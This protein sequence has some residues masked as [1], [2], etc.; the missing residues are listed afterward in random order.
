MRAIIRFFLSL[1]TAVVFFAVF[2]AIA[3]AGS[4]SLVK[5][6]AFF[7][8]IDDTP[9]FRWLM[10]AHAFRQAWWIYAMILVIGLL[11][12]NTLFC[13]ADALL[14]KTGLKYLVRKLSPELIHVGVLLVMLGHLLTASVGFKAD[15]VIKKGESKAVTGSAAISVNDVRLRTDAEG[16]ARDWEADLQWSDS[17]GQSIQKVLRPVRP[18]Y[19]GQFGIYIKAVSLQP[20]PSV[21]VRV[22]RDLGA[23]WALGGGVLLSIGCIA[24]LILK[25]QRE[26]G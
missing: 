26:N 10:E 3:I 5:N 21:Q 2:M 17:R 14:K 15:M 8:G 22:C 9:L 12:V 23:P 19:F 25:L 6:L 18:L 4:L 7:S 1:K 16:Y 11:A 24:V 13:T 20:E